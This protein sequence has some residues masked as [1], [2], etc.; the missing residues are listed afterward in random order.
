M[1][2]NEDV[3]YF[4]SE[5]KE[6]RKL[7]SSD[8]AFDAVFAHDR[9]WHRMRKNWAKKQAKV[10]KNTTVVCVFKTRLAEILAQLRDKRNSQT[11]V[12]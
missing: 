8:V 5:A 7:G 1:S 11:S 4:G 2:W 9:F 6:L 3:W 12:P 10:R